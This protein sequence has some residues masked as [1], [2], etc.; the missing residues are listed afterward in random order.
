MRFLYFIMYYILNYTLRL[1]FRKVKVIN[2]PPKYGKTIFVSNHA[3]SFMDPLAIA[4]FNRSIVFFMTR[5]DVFTTFTKP[6]FWLAHMLPIYRKRDGVNTKEK[7]TEVFIKC[8]ETL[9]RNRNL[10]IFGEGF[11]DDTFVRRLKPI[12]KG[13]IRIGFATLEACNWKENIYVAAVGC[14]YSNPA[15]FGS[16]LIIKNS[17]SILLNSYKTE[18]EENPS[19]VIS[20]LT[21]L[22][23]QL[24]KEQLTHVEDI[25]NTDYH[26]KIMMLERKGMADSFM[27]QPN[28]EERWMYSSSLAKKLNISNLSITPEIKEDLDSYFQ[29]LEDLGF[30]DDLFYDSI[31][32]PFKPFHYL[33]QFLLLPFSILGVVHCAFFY[34][35]IKKFVENKFGRAVFWGSTKLIMMIFIAGPVNLIIFAILPYYIGWPLS[36][37]YFLLIPLFG[38]SFYKSMRFWVRV[39]QIRRIKRQNHKNIKEEREVLKQKIDKFVELR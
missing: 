33:I 38:F 8:T 34:F 15:I 36:I 19:R 35:S 27:S 30:S 28:L 17:D 4:A 22:I 21:Q 39:F 2:K 26:E 31:H 29:K 20:K 3:A 18:Y 24:L 5:S 16:D 23:E 13:A 11:T 9:L 32:R 25:D 37:C 14:N 7:N 6:I 10:L 1:Y 12:K